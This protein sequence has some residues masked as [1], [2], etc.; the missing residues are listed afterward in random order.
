MT[1]A[2]HTR[3]PAQSALPAQLGSVSPSPHSLRLKNTLSHDL[4]LD[5]DLGADNVR[6]AEPAPSPSPSHPPDLSPEPPASRDRDR[7]APSSLDT[8]SDPAPAMTAAVSR[9]FLGH[10]HGHGHTHPRRD[11]SYSR[12]SSSPSP[13]PVSPR[14]RTSSFPALDVP[15]L[16]NSTSAS[17]SHP[18]HA[19]NHTRAERKPR[20]SSR[21][22]RRPST[23]NLHYQGSASSAAWLGTD[24]DV[25]GDHFVSVNNDDTEVEA[26][27]PRRQALASVAEGRA[28]PSP[29]AQAAPLPRSSVNLRLPADAAA[30]P[31]PARLALLPHKVTLGPL[32]FNLTRKRAEDAILLGALVAGIVKLTYKWNEVALAGGRSCALRWQC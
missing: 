7:D 25:D 17:L 11:R 3:P 6:H 24:D 18:H 1:L 27:R 14:Q 4:D 8:P 12:S 16:S 19:S 2:S 30:H 15:H 10:T 31:L 28:S 20:T 13:P 21:S 5:L 9:R 26:R 32:R 23:G 29:R 22:G